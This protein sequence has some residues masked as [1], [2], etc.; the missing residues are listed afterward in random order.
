MMLSSPSHL[1]LQLLFA[2]CTFVISEVY[3]IKPTT[4]Y[5][6]SVHDQPCVTL[7]DFVVNAR[8]NLSSYMSLILLRGN[9]SL[10]LNFQVSFI[11]KFQIS[12]HI[13][14][15]WII[16]EESNKKFHS[17]NNI[18]TVEIRNLRVLGCGGF[19]IKYVD[20]FS[21]ENSI[22]LQNNFSYTKDAAMIAALFSTIEIWHCSF[23]RTY[24]GCIVGLSHCN[25]SSYHSIY[26]NNTAAILT[27]EESS[28]AAFDSCLFQNNKAAYGTFIHSNSSALI[29]QD[30]IWE[31]SIFQKN[32]SREFEYVIICLRCI[33]VIRETT[34][35]NTQS[36]AAEGSGVLLGLYSTISLCN[37]KFLYNSGKK[38][39][40]LDEI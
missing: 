39:P 40:V 35:N 4:D 12:S 27:M 33:A 1:C 14:S 9:H 30:S 2:T 20:N 34:I 13:N 18:T 38:K 31:H 36:Y 3:Y 10:S 5:V 32:V 22:F 25:L 21:A 7:D 19:R 17:F 24:N 28:I 16:C 29:I 6:C 11:E 23:I 15:S 26:N 8:G 37:C